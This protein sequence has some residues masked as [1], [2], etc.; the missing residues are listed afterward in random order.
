MY[1]VVLRNPGV[2][3]FWDVEL[4]AIHDGDEADRQVIRQVGPQSETD[5]VFLLI[6][7]RYCDQGT[8]GVGRR[9]RGAAIAEALIDGEVVASVELPGGGAEARQHDE[10]EIDR[11]P[12]SPDEEEALLR[13]RPD[14]WEYMYFAA[15][16]LR[17]RNALEPRYRDHELRLA[18]PAR[19]SALDGAESIRFI[20]GSF[21]EV[22][23]L[24][25]NVNRVLD[26]AAQEQAFGAPGD[27]GDPAQ[28]EHLASRLISVYD[29][30]LN[31]AARLRSTPVEEVFERMVELTSRFVDG[32]IRQFRDFVTR[33][34]AECDRLPSLL[35][36]ETPEPIV[37]TLTLKLEIEDGLEQELHAELRRLEQLIEAWGS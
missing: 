12:R 4:R 30:L 35:R 25:D 19:R 16:L 22:R 15:V 23:M 8:P 2:G 14:G 29:G 32:P 9:P 11:V 21:P 6:P 17:C 33:V 24:T 36:T 34:V 27:P 31:W 37:L 28:I 13:V 3:T 1:P 5:P 10:G 26:A 20:L 18:R 7:A